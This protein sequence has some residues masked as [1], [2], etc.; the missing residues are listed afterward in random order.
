MTLYYANGWSGQ[1]SVVVD[2]VRVNVLPSPV[3]TYTYYLYNHLDISG[4][5]SS[6]VKLSTIMQT[7]LG[8][9]YAVSLS[10]T[11][12][13]YTISQASNFTLFFDS[14]SATDTLLAHALGFDLD[15]LYTGTNTYTG[16]VRPYFLM[17]P[18]EL[19]RS[20]ALP[21][22]YEPDDIVTE[23]VSDGGVPYSISRATTEL[24]SDWTQ[25]MEAKEQCYSISATASVPYTW[26][27]FFR[28]T[29]GTHPI[30]VVDSGLGNYV[31]T[32]RAEGSVFSPKPVVSD[33]DALYNISFKA[34]WLGEL[35]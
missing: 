32:L 6:Y 31:Y 7:T 13:L 28:D 30:A 21:I 11:T 22:Y 24:R 10:T 15:F 26:Q 19:A 12:W 1:M 3:S 35:A 9:S 5:V 18:T 4:V 14:T 23:A 33:W 29:R 8:G 2:S 20:Q 25:T 17:V 34:R 27:Q 16:S